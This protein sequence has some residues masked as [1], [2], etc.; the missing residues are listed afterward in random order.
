MM[1]CTAAGRGLTWCFFNR[2]K[3]LDKFLL[4]VILI[5]PQDLKAQKT[6]VPI[7]L[8][9]EKLAA[10][11]TAFYITAV[12]DERADRGAVAWLL[13][14]SEVTGGMSPYKMDMKHGAQA[15]ITQ[16]VNNAMPI[17]NTLRPVVIRIKKLRLAENKLREGYIEGK[18]EMILSFD[19][20]RVNDAV[21]LIDYNTSSAYYRLQG[22]QYDTEILFR[23]TIVGGLVYFNNWINREADTNI[24]LAK[25]VKLLFTDYTEQPEGDTIYYSAKRPLR[26]DDFKGKP[27]GGKYE[28]SVLP[29]IGYTERV[30]IAKGVVNIHLNV[31]TYLPKSASWVR[32]GSN[33]AYSLNHEQRHFDIVK[34]FAE[35]FK[36]KLRAETLPVDNYDGYINVQYLESFREMNVLQEQYDA[37]TGHG[38]NPYAQ[39]QWNEKIDKE[40]SGEW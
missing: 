40:L 32:N 16:F 21:H 24:K 1:N 4:L 20:K 17:N 35:R 9:N 6:T 31:K 19:L 37:E 36:S 23:H 34:L 8:K 10:L 7:V 5:I 18:L 27:Q 2:L 33:S 11:P 14:A 39:Q 3:L 12:T 22:Q 13:P 26:W 28:A 38:T 25:G 15:A 30:D 29:G